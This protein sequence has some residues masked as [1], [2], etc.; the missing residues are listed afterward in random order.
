MFI[1][2][3]I[4]HYP[5]TE[6]WES[7]E[8]SGL[9]QY[10]RGVGF[11]FLYIQPCL[12]DL[13]KSQ[14][15]S[16]WS[17]YYCIVHYVWLLLTGKLQTRLCIFSNVWWHMFLMTVKKN[18]LIL[19]STILIPDKHVYWLSCSNIDSMALV[20]WKNNYLLRAYVNLWPVSPSWFKR[21]FLWLV[22]KIISNSYN[23]IK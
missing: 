10:G 15:W 19:D 21:N 20:T 16:C 8:Q 14:R 3:I 5:C 13:S 1:P 12:C 2:N 11:L 22:S 7:P 17:Q 4:L 9:T 6:Y 23:L 18:G